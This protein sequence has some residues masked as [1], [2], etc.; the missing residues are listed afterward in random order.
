MTLMLFFQKAYFR[1]WVALVLGAIEASCIYDYPNGCPTEFSFTIV[2]D[3]S[4]CRNPDPEGM[5]YLFFPADGSPVW[6]FDFQG[7]KAGEVS[8]P[9]G[10]YNVISHNDDTSSILFYEKDGYDGYTAECLDGDLGFMAE[11]RGE[12][13]DAPPLA[14][15]GEPVKR[16]PDML[17]G[18]AYC[19][20][21]LQEGRLSYMPVGEIPVQPSDAEVTVSEDMVVVM[22]QQPLVARYDYRIENVENLDGVARIRAALSGMA[23]SLDIPS[24]RR[25]PEAVTLPFVASASGKDMI[26]GNFFSFGLPSGTE[27]PNILSLYVWLRDGRKFSYEF[28][29]SE[30]VRNAADPMN[31]S[32]V[33]RGLRIEPSDM[34]GGGGF[35]VSVD[36]WQTVV[37]NIQ[38]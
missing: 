8:L 34:V 12:H 35:D 1:I 3:W 16:C 9:E 27:D 29:V 25:G 26:T 18:V 21:E 2:N 32:I 15:A 5:A 19:D 10:K 30:Q 6:R 36:G 11:S 22:Y 7:M 31:V 33:V 14:R 23:G 37:V 20:F 38:G 13:I 24:G 17:W 28:D 4:K